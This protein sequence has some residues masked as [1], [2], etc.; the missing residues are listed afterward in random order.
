MADWRTYRLLLAAQVRGQASYRA[1]F[2]LDLVS[3]GVIP[4][5]D[6]LSIMVMFRVT[7]DLG[8][9]G[10]SE[11]LII[12]GLSATAFAL[13]DLAVGNVEKIRGYVRQG[14][15]DTV[16]IRPLGVLGQLVTVDFA[17]RRVTRVV[18]ASGI[19]ALSL[20]RVPV[21]WRPTRVVLVLATPIVGAVFFSAI[22]VA[23]A[24]VA[25]WWIESGELA[26]SITY[27][28]RDFTMVPATVYDGLFRRVFAYALGFAFVGYYPTLAL[29]G[30]SDPLG[31]PAWVSWCSPA[32]A[33]VAVGVAALI[34]R[35]GVR[36]YRSTG[37]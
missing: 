3:N 25:F 37:S 19:L 22:F 21:D 2:A 23:T 29:L 1:S 31:A 15:L 11:V 9:F 34:W 12:Y 32:V 20:G 17:P 6:L 13:A 28:G 4:L 33:L 27:G 10:A 35:T 36:H 14:L 18:V 30:R 26:S 24:T 5:L 16:L 8:G 7:R